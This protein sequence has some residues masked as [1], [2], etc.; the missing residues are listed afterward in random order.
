MSG[1]ILQGDFVEQTEVLAPEKK[2]EKELP[3]DA[4]APTAKDAGR[5]RGVTK[6]ATAIDEVQ[7][8]P[9]RK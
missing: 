9:D 5:L 4:Q 6:F 7:D 2:E 1:T 3:A 8:F